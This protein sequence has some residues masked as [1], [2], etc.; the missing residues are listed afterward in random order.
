MTSCWSSCNLVFLPGIK[1]AVACSLPAGPLL[2]YP[3]FFAILGLHLSKMVSKKR[4]TQEEIYQPLINKQ[5][6]VIISILHEHRETLKE[7]ESNHYAI[8]I[9][10]QE[11]FRHVECQV[12]DDELEFQL[13]RLFLLHSG[14]FY[15]LPDEYAIKLIGM[16]YKGTDTAMWYKSA[17]NFGHDPICAK[18]I[19]DYNLEQTSQH[20]AHQIRTDPDLV[21]YVAGSTNNF[22]TE[23][24]TQGPGSPYMRVF[25]RGTENLQPLQGLL[26]QL[27]T[28]RKANLTQRDHG[29]DNLT[30]YLQRPYTLEEMTNQVEA[31]LEAYFNKMPNDPIFKSETLSEISATAYFQVLDYMIALGES[32]E[33]AKR[34]VVTWDENMFRDYFLRYL[35]TISKAIPPQ[36]SPLTQQAKR[37]SYFATKT[38]RTC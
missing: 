5:Y 33:K 21:K 6:A 4:L 34:S 35:D 1:V 7:D 22:Y 23:V 26:N 28:L 11:L 17:K 12:A 32:L 8:N 9:F 19:A 3:L 2:T 18:I 29:K 36:G 24:V 16:L 31:T 14:G 10:L 20:S 38:K 25:V 27:P 37:I 13:L 15:A 30:L